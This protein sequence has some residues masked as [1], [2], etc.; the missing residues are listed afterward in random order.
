MK[1]KIP[2]LF[3]FL[4]MVTAS[5][6]GQQTTDT[7]KAEP[8]TIDPGKGDPQQ[9]LKDIKEKKNETF[10]DSTANNPKQETSID[11]TVYNRYG[12]LLNDDTA[13]N[14]KS[15]LWIPAAEVV[16]VV[17]L[18]WAF[19][20]YILK[21]DYAQVN[22]ET[23]KSNIKE[24]WEWDADK[25]GI[26]FIGHPYSGALSFNAGRSLGHNFTT[27]FGL[28]V[29]GSVLWEY[30]GET[31]RPSYNDI[32]ST[33]ISGAFLGEVLYR[34]SSNLLDDR[35]R[36]MHRVVRE[37]AAGIVNPVRG[38]NRLFD[39]KAYRV[40][41]KE[42][43][44][45]EPLNISMLAGIQQRNYYD[46]SELGKGA[47]NPALNIQLDYGNAFE[48]RSRKPFDFFRLRVDLSFGY[49]R[50][51][52]D[53]VVG[54]GLLVGKNYGKD[55]AAMLFGLFQH[56]DYWDNYSFEMGA[57]AIGPG[58]ITK[59]P[60]QALGIENNLYTNF[61]LGI[62]PLA[63]KSGDQGVDSN[64]I[65][66]DYNFGWGGE[67]K[68]EVALN[69]GNITTLSVAGYYYYLHT[70][71]GVSEKA[72]LGILKP[73]IH[74]TVYRNIKVG[75]EQTI[76]YDDSFR[77]SGV[78]NNSVHTEQKAFVLIYLEDKQRKGRYQ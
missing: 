40:T 17:G 54:Y 12:D 55:K 44:Q 21:A 46:D 42:V 8:D 69:I 24:G 71:E 70:Y 15:P 39:G 35:T 19:D 62:V 16:G 38:I 5:I 51:M 41:N 4:S 68:L 6:Y 26:N 50:K 31:T 75:Y 61:H 11:T 56:Y 65:V 28:A 14:K 1:N 29:F 53:N 9:Q 57:L 36:G 59:Y 34:I 37:I 30:F 76:Q 10:S 78:S 33:P 49:G 60:F 67:T 3:F 43:Y 45:E 27:S 77:S 63:G 74:F 47:A 2:L 22:S 48:I 52:I 72:F 64:A 18:T 73:K 20:K 23:W 13:Y 7:E 32:I 25:F 66:R 58:I